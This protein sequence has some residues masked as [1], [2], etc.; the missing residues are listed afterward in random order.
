MRATPVSPITAT[1]WQADHDQRVRARHK[2]LRH[3]LQAVPR[4]AAWRAR[5]K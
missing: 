4:E 3:L 2:A 1:L 5:A